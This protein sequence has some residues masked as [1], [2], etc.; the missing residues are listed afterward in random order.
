MMVNWMLGHFF[1]ISCFSIRKS[2]SFANAKGDET[3]DSGLMHL[4]I[5]KDNE[6]NEDKGSL[7]TKI[8]INLKDMPALECV[9]F[10]EPTT[11]LHY[12]PFLTPFLGFDLMAEG[13][14]VFHMVSRNPGPKFSPNLDDIFQTYA[15]S[16]Q[17]GQKTNSSDT[18]NIASDFGS[19]K[20]DE[21]S[22]VST[23]DFGCFIKIDR[24]SPCMDIW[25][26]RRKHTYKRPF[27]STIEK[28][29]FPYGLRRA[30][31]NRFGHFCLPST[32]SKKDGST[33]QGAWV[34][35]CGVHEK[36]DGGKHDSL[37]ISHRPSTDG[38]KDQ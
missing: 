23:S 33:S 19:P 37:F 22:A 16:M 28:F 6:D 31:Q 25:V 34:W 11:G 12:T 3:A 30:K 15:M 8:G 27:L 24:L 38:N 18:E 35:S 20:K 1:K 36:R 9:V 29:I 4:G 13:V 10:A 2:R 21:F 5:R 17:S 26:E 32:L 14:P 7:G